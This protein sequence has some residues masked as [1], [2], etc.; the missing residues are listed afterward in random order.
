MTNFRDKLN[1]INPGTEKVVVGMSGGVDSA[2]AAAL[3]K[4]RGYRVTG[5]T[6]KIWAGNDS[7]EESIH[8][9]CYGPG[10]GDDIEDASNVCRILGIPYHVIDLTR[11]YK[12][13]VL[14]YY[15]AEY[16]AGRTPNPCFKC[17]STV[18]FG[19]LVR[20]TREAGID[21]DFFATGHYARVKYDENT[22]RYLLLK[23][24][25]LAKD[26]SY[27]ISAL[28]QEQLAATMFPLA[29]FNKSEVRA[30]AKGFGLSVDEKPESQDFIAGGYQSL[31]AAQ[32][33]GRIVNK[34]GD[35]LGEHQGI[36]FY[37]IGQRKGLGISAPEPQYVIDIDAEN[38]TIIVGDK[39]DL[40]NNE[41][42]AGGL[43]W[44]AID[45]LT[46]P[47]QVEARIRYRHK[48]SKA[49]LTPMDDNKAHVR[50]S[51][52][53]ISITPGQTVVFYEGDMVIGAGTILKSKE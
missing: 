33:A 36:P 14:D 49:L 50:F 37:T 6:M 21:F 13:E 40:L 7:V 10:E 1:L 18:K 45:R 38:N 39:E 47:M 30:L 8:H 27:F 24:A 15:C 28:T 42:V 48:E 34:A 29:D 25:D 31:I 23:A 26:Q 2:V 35:T 4:E 43:N 22:K 5:V 16:T 17:N 9:A 32:P 41:L 3:I 52:P 46:E 19:A 11:E 51:E 44:I 20:K 12:A 53:Q